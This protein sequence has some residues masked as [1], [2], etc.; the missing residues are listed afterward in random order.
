MWY[1][2]SMSNVNNF[3]EAKEAI[4]RLY[5]DMSAGLSE[6]FTNLWALREYINALMDLVASDMRE[7]E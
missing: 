1:D 4:N 6:T 2:S 3:D 7:E 5:Y